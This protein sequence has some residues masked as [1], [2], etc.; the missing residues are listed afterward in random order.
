MTHYI[1]FFFFTIVK[2]GISVKLVRLI[3]VC[4]TE[5]YTK[6]H[7]G[8]NLRVFPIQIGL[9]QGDALVPLIFNFAFEYAI[10]KVKENEEGLEMN[11]KHCADDVNMLGENVNTRGK[12]TEVLIEASREVGVHVNREKTKCMVASPPEYRYTTIY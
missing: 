7:I 1:E 12:I 10:R 5:T 11:G 3:K 9:K 4:L 8:R 6:V 2:F